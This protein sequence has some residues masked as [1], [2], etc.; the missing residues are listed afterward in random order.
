MNR[1]SESASESRWP[2]DIQAVG[3][4]SEFGTTDAGS[5]NSASD[6]DLRKS[7]QQLVH[8]QLLVQVQLFYACGRLALHKV[9]IARFGRIS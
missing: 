6:V 2:A 1:K 3:C 9:T 4:Y 5:G 7:S 8:L